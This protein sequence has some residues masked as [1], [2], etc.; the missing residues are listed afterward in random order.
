MEWI[1]V[2]DRLPERGQDVLI[3][4][5]TGNNMAVGFITGQDKSLSFW[6]TYTDDGWYTDCDSIPQFWMPIPEP[7]KEME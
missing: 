4:F 2:E 3:Y 6:A 1:S 5:E 7:P